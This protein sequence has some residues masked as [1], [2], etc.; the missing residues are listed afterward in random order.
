MGDSPLRKARVA[1]GWDTVQAAAA[2][3]LN[4]SSISRI[5]TGEQIPTLFTAKLLAEI[6]KDQ[7]LTRDMI[8][9]PEEY[10]DFVPS[11]KKT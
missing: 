11:V 4:K 1:R 6:Y 2:C 5:E 8:F 3:A 9:Y 7:G 10:P